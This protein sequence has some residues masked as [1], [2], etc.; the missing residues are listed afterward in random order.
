MSGSDAAAAPGAAGDPMVMRAL[1][2]GWQMAELYAA[3]RPD[4]LRPPGLPAGHPEPAETDPPAPAGPQPR[5]Q[6]QADLPGAGSLAEPAKRQLMFDEVDV[7]VRYLQPLLEAAGLATPDNSDWPELGRHLRSAEGRYQLAAAVLRFHDELLI[8]LTAADRRLGQA[9]GLGRALADLSL[10]PEAANQR[11]FTDDL[12]FGGRMITMNNWLRELRT[13]LPDHAAGA[14]AGSVAQWQA[15]AATPRWGGGPMRWSEHGPSVIA[16]LRMQGTRWRSLLTGRSGPLDA[17][18]PEDY[19]DA[20]GFLLGRIRKILQRLLIQYWPAVLLG[21][22][23]M[24]TAVIAALI[25]FETPADKA[26][27]AGVSFLAWLG[28]TGRLVSVALQR[29][30]SQAENSLWQ[31]E[32][33]LAVAWAITELPN[34]ACDRRLGEPARSMPRAAAARLAKLTGN[35]KSP[36]VTPH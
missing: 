28:I 22:L 15:W 17:L 1:D 33:D 13:A 5:N 32:L 35:A 10:R 12:R 31:G 26:I 3:V 30:V 34:S 20:A 16:A 6:L 27:S 21:T 24:V 2:L 19:V 36:A 25:A 8:R 4:T 23:L 11:S 14:V 9:Y 29:V 18:S 7:S